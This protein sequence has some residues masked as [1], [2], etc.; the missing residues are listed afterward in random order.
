MLKRILILLTLITTSIG[1]YTMNT[2]AANCPNPGESK[3]RCSCC[4]NDVCATQ[5][6]ATFC[7]YWCTHITHKHLIFI[8]CG[9]CNDH[10][11]EDNR[12][13]CY[14]CDINVN[15][16]VPNAKCSS[17]VAAGTCHTFCKDH[18]RHCSECGRSISNN[19]DA[20]PDS[21]CPN[22]ANRM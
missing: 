8:T 18:C 14:G 13:G 12:C 10:C 17:C 11:P 1:L 19:N 22:Y 3:F 7:D 2:W 5:A 6:F 4:N 20:C 15:S 9:Y 16:P 21:N